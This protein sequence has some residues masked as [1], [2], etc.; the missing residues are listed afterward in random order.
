MAQA[1]LEVGDLPRAQRNAAES[2]SILREIGA[3]HEQSV[4][5]LMQ[6]DTLVAEY[7]KGADIRRAAELL[8]QA[9]DVARA[10]LDVSLEI[11]IRHWIDRARQ[12]VN[13]VSGL[14]TARAED[15][16]PSVRSMRE[17]YQRPRN[18]IIH[19]S[20][21][22]RDLLQLCDVYADTGEPV[23]I[24]GET[25]TGKELVASRIHASS[26][27]AGREMVAVNVSAIPADLFEREF[28][29]HVKGA[30]SGADR[31][32]QGYAG[33]AD[34]STLFLDEIGDLPLAVQPKL[35]RLLQDGTY[36]ALGDP[37]QRR[38]DLRL[39][40]AT[41]ADLAQRVQEGSFRADLYYR[42]KILELD[43]PPV[44]RRREDILLLLRHFLSQAAGRPVDL[45]HYFDQPSLDRILAYRWP[46]NVR[47]IAM[48]ARRA[49]VELEAK[50]RVDLVLMGENGDRILLTGPKPRSL[51]AMAAE[52]GGAFDAEPAPSLATS[53]AVE[54][55][56]IL[57]ALEESGGSKTL[58]ARR[59]GWSRST[60]Y[61]RM[62]KLEIFSPDD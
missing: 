25:G 62:K 46:G 38:A 16:Q 8:D 18:M 53:R 61:R 39:I 34:G 36:Q 27:R 14:R 22:M 9:W 28:F 43:L 37:A 60:L 32:G 17:G 40:A 56:R 42:L 30:Y 41:N 23:L 57:L 3:R 31:D 2:V 1:G 47:E 20:T 10:A 35:L 33:R 55:S 5:Q 44:R 58:A 49:A 51:A 19:T 4:S 54:R 29:G 11:G 45:S 59:L 7:E 21:V 52:S 12:S 48:V 24:T 13:R 6:V 26:R 15:R 50:K